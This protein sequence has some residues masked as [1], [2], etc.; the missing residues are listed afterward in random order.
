MAKQPPISPGTSQEE[1]FA[2]GRETCPIDK[3]NKQQ[4]ARVPVRIQWDISL[5][6]ALRSSWN[7]ADENDSRL[8]D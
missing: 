8:E 6:K 2:K 3:A 4:G 1:L 5:H 7:N